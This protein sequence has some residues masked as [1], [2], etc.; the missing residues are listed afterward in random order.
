MCLSH[1]GS[2]VRCYQR[3]K[4]QL[5]RARVLRVSQMASGSLDETLR[6]WD[7]SS[8]NEITHFAFSS[9]IFCAS[10]HPNSSHVAVGLENA[11]IEVIN[12]ADPRVK[13]K[14]SMHDQS[15]MSVRYSNDGDWMVSTGRDS[16]VVGWRAPIGGSIFHAREPNK[17]LCSDISA[18][19]QFLATGSAAGFACLYSM[20]Y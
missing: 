2:R 9:P 14:L 4:A 13:F 1:D 3:G 11:Q 16:K 6:V 10:L 8:G 5:T 17:V 20:Q 12:V 18:N 15:V 19:D 7:V